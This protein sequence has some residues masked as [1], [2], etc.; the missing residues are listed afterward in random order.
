MPVESLSTRLQIVRRRM[1]SCRTEQAS[2][3]ADDPHYRSANKEITDE[4][5]KGN[6]KY[7]FQYFGKNDGST[8]IRIY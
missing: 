3:A 7:A 2:D 1:E 5:T 8:P 6:K 4:N